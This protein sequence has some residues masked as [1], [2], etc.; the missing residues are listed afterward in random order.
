[1]IILDPAVAPVIGLAD[2]VC[3]LFM[4]TNAVLSTVVG[5]SKCTVTKVQADVHKAGMMHSSWGLT[6]RQVALGKWH[7]SF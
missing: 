7:S 3:F 1:M 5:L 6:L 4:H 2:F